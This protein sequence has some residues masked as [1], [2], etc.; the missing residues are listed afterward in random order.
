MNDNTQLIDQYLRDEMTATD[1][2]AFESRLAADK[3]LQEELKIQQAL[4]E[5]IK[6]AG[7]KQQFGRAIQNRMI[8]NRLV[9]LAV[10]VIIAAAVY[11]IYTNRDKL[12]GHNRETDLPPTIT[13]TAQAEIENTEDTLV[14]LRQSL[15]RP[16]FFTIDNSADT[17]IETN[18]GLV[19]GVPAHA[20]NSSNNIV[21]LSIRTA[22]NAYD[23]IRNGLSAESNGNLLQTAGM[24]YINGYEKGKP[25]S[26]LKDITVSV[27]A[28]KRNPK[29]Q[30][31]DGVADS[32]GHINW[33]NPK[34]IEPTLRTYDITTL[35]FYPPKYIPLLKTLNKK[36]RD[37]Q[38]TDSLYY[39]F[40]GYPPHSI[41][42]T[43]KTIEEEKTDSSAKQLPAPNPRPLD[44]QDTI[45][46]LTADTTWPIRDSAIE[47]ELYHYEIDPARI[48]AI[49]NKRYNNTILATKEFEERLHFL[50]GLCTSVYLDAYLAGLNKPLYEIDQYCASI[51]S[52]EVRKKFL[53][54]A[55]RKDGAV[56]ISAGMQAK[57]NEYFQQRYKIYQEAAI[58]TR[59]KYEDS[60]ANLD[61]IAD[62]KKRTAATRDFIRNQKNLDEEYCI[63]ITDAYRQI[64][65]EK[66]CN[67]T[68]PP[69]TPAPYYYTVT[70]ST[71]GWKNLDAYVYEA[72]S[73]RSSMTYTDPVTGKAATVTYK[74]LSIRIS[75]GAQFENLRVYLIPDGLTSFQRLKQSG[76]MF[77]EKM[78]ASFKY[79][80]VAVGWIGTK[81]YVYK[82]KNLSPG[83][84]VFELTEQP[85]AALRTL[86]SEYAVV[87][88]QDLKAEWESQLFEQQEAI[89]QIQVSMDREFRLQVAA[90]IF[91]CYS[92]SK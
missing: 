31:F 13:A 47:T 88:Q 70:I 3:S 49:W 82:V 55:A 57:L 17:I 5:A 80:A 24:F 63:N 44:F 12:F 2:T 8:I 69:R 38:Y 90:S 15:A 50:H 22:L 45:S 35:D 25:L 72:T 77:N 29:M 20:F 58:K 91:S 28:Q 84:H 11:V 48:K 37:K 62:E 1:K 60:L 16:E 89:R 78:N 26:L 32:N 36:Y 65:V 74:D 42:E 79:D 27:P 67:D 23:I 59:E 83:S 41:P 18:D 43:P 40:S 6:S 52:G 64:G 19:V 33:V 87:K 53:A 10:V 66:H 9:K 39:S 75:N 85:G 81:M 34:P 68:I 7:V 30:L 21:Q 76:D 73:N 86:T 46:R 4:I 51:S 14:T 92:Q 56:H 71:P 54:F 61:R